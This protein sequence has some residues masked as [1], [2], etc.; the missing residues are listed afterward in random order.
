MNLFHLWFPDSMLFDQKR[1]VYE[2]VL[3]KLKD[4]GFMDSYKILDVEYR[5]SV[6]QNSGWYDQNIVNP[7]QKHWWNYGYNK[8]LIFLWSFIF[9]LFFS[10]ANLWLYPK[11]MD[12]VYSIE[13]LEKIDQ[14]KGIGKTKWILH[15]LQTITYTFI[16]FFG[17]KMD[18][19]KFKKAAV[20]QHPILFV[21][22]MSIYVIG[23]VCLG[24]I[25][26]FIIGK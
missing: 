21:Y 6:Y 16:I 5:Y 26:N 24:F 25:V 4:D 10:F 14:S 11:L 1:S 3:K 12:R 7:L 20:S 23:L 22:L 8:E 18:L 9:L 19:E 2:S 13:F 17:F 15:F